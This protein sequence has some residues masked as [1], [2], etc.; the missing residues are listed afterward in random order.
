M[1]ALGKTWLWEGILPM[2]HPCTI[3]VASVASHHVRSMCVSASGLLVVPYII[4]F[5]DD[6]NGPGT[7]DQMLRALPAIDKAGV[8]E[9]EI[10]DGRELANQAEKRDR[11]SLCLGWL[12]GP[13]KKLR[14]VSIDVEYGLGDQSLW[15]TVL[16]NLKRHCPK[17]EH[18]SMYSYP[19]EVVKALPAF[20]NLTSLHMAIR[21]TPDATVASML[22]RLADCS[23]SLP[24][25]D[26]LLL[27]VSPGTEEIVPS[28]QRCLDAF[29]L[30][31]ARI[32]E[33]GRPEAPVDGLLP[34]ALSHVRWPPKCRTVSLSSLFAGEEL[35]RLAQHI[36]LGAVTGFYVTTGPSTEAAQARR[37]LATLEGS[38]LKGFGWLFPDQEV[39]EEVLKAIEE[40]ACGLVQRL[41]SLRVLEIGS[42]SSAV[43][44]PTLAALAQEN[45]VELRS[46]DSGRW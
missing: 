24:A 45:Q 36:C 14:A 6:F 1:M 12:L 40:G 41:K 4:V 22:E 42:W 26:T 30:L 32:I 25:L 27:E 43:A 17:L 28:L 33:I 46:P 38:Q 21:S 18:L 5:C 31:Y 16:Q 29:P 34:R 13:F 9:I 7:T 23:A 44:P 8:I 3:A 19:E 15:V 35:C 37:F 11:F 39:S 2:L 10:C 20:A